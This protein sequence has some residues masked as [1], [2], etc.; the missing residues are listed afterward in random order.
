M[1]TV[2]AEVISWYEV[3][4]LVRLLFREVELSDE[5]CLILHILNKALLLLLLLTTALNED[6]IGLSDG[7]WHNRGWA[8]W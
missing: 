2:L 4:L 3:D 7:S 8:R 5:G 6:V 1:R